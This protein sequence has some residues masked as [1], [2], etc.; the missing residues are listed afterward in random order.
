[1]KKHW[2][3]QASTMCSKGLGRAAALVAHPDP[4]CNKQMRK[5]KNERRINICKEQQDKKYQ[6]SRKTIR[7]RPDGRVRS[8]ATKQCKII[9]GRRI[10]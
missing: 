8:E 2:Q 5:E 6:A 3:G 9:S 7:K 4:T 1:M 10:V